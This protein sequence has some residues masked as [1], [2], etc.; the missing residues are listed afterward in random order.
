LIFLAYAHLRSQPV[1]LKR[2]FGEGITGSVLPDSQC[3]IGG[4]H[5][6]PLQLAQLPDIDLPLPDIYDNKSL[7]VVYHFPNQ[8]NPHHSAL[9]KGYQRPARVL[10]GEDCDKLRRKGWYNRE[11]GGGG[12]RGGGPSTRG[13]RSTH[14]DPSITNRYVERTQVDYG[15]SGRGSSYQQNNT[16]IPPGRRSSDNVVNHSSRGRGANH[17]RGG[18][19]TSRGRGYNYNDGYFGGRVRPGIGYSNVA[20]GYNHRGQTSEPFR[21]TDRVLYDPY[22]SGASNRGTLHRGRGLNRQ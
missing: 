7:S 14:G 13:Y 6:C 10:S 15:Y 1:A 9:L 11:Q 21:R 12:V 20:G 16:Y 18:N 5:Y 19:Y 22:E 4:T 2:G 8:R 3:I 17:Q